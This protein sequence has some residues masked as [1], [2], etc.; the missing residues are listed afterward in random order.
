MRTL[1]STLIVLSSTAA[2]AQ[3]SPV[4]G[5][6]A[7]PQ[8]WQVKTRELYQTAIEI[9]TV[10]G[11]GEH[12]RMADY[13]SAQYRANGWRADDVQVLP[14]DSQGEK[15][16]AF[17]ARWPAAQPSGK[18]PILLIA[19]MD[20]VEAKRSD[21]VLDPFKF[22]E[23]D[24]YFYGRGT[25]DDKQGVIATTAALFKLRADGFKPTR[26]I[27]VFYTADEETGGDGARLGATEWRKLLDAEYALN[28]DAGGGSWDRSGRSLGFGIQTAE[29]I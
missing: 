25:S 4:N 15:K 5:P 27:I 22:V 10:A 13:L 6:I 8:Q 20:V 1:A 17:Y 9:P 28:A 21:W 26:D 14:Y 2:V 16:F 18:K 23:K 11:R 24:G 3:T 7:L 29:K 19:H 12:K